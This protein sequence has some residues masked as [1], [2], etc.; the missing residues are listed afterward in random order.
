[1]LRMAA[2]HGMMLV[3]AISG[4]VIALRMLVGP[5]DAPLRVRIPLNP[6]GW[7]GVALTAL[8]AIRPSGSI[9]TEQHHQ[10]RNGWWNAAAIAALIGFT[11]AA[12]WRT[13][14]FYFLSD[15]FILVKIANSP[16]AVIRSWFTMAG[17][18]G[19]F[20]P[21]GYISLTLTSIWAGVNPM[22][23]HATALSLH[24]ANVVLVFALATRLGASRLAA[25]FA[26]ALFGVHGTRPEAAAWIA[27]RFDLV[28]TFFVLLALLFFIRFHREAASIG[29]LYALASLVCMVLAI[30]SK[31][32]AYIFPFLVALFLLAKR[33]LCRRRMGVLIPFFVVA[34]ALFAYRWRLFG[35]IG[36]YGDAQTGKAQALTFGLSTVKALGL[37]LW[38]A[39]YFPINWSVGPGAWMA[40]LMIAYIGAL[41]WLTTTRPNRELMGFSFGF[42]IVSALPPLHLLA[43]GAGLGNSR[44]LYLPSVGF[45]LMLAVAVDGLSG[46]VRWIIPTVILAFNFATLQHNLD[47]WEYASEKAKATSAA[48]RNCISP[49]V[50]EIVVSGIPSILR[51]VPFFANGLLEA[52]ELHTSGVP[53]TVTAHEGDERPNSHSLV[54]NRTTET[55]D[56]VCRGNCPSGPGNAPK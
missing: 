5:F 31:E 51:G 10:Q 52:I 7:F 53:L 33:D 49:G 9:A 35:G 6:E 15:D 41:V 2:R 22:A 17:G 39:L 48:A 28:A 26:T 20:R 38:M 50:G 25:S 56:C 54:W 21:I 55:A 47:S 13:P 37:R 36:G 43:I 8:L 16:H 1:M 18:D 4:L 19:F 32:S 29:Y 30:L 34:A 42:V 11:T 24:V 27:G 46:R 12:F 23:W 14:H 3:A 45:C 44:L 40:A